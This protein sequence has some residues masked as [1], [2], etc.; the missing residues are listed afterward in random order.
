MN[1]RKDDR[2][3]PP[4]DAEPTLPEQTSDDRDVGW[5]DEP[6]ERDDEWYRRERPPHHGD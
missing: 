3:P 4:R 2:G 5:G 6:A 1:D